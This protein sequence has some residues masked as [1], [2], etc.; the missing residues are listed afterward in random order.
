MNLLRAE[1]IIP[2]NVRVIGKRKRDAYAFER[3]VIN[4]RRPLL[5]KH[6]G[7]NG[8]RATTNRRQIPP[9]VKVMAKIGTRAY[10]AKVLLRYARHLKPAI[11]ADVVYVAVKG[12]TRAENSHYSAGA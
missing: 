10:A 11:L 4:D 2:T 8:S 5:N 3:L 6:P 12:L 1:D 9:W 7:G